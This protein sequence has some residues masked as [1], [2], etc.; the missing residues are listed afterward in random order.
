MDRLA[1]AAAWYEPQSLEQA[2]L[3]A[4]F[5]SQ[6]VDWTELDRWVAGEG[7]GEMPEVRA[8]YGRTRG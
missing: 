1:A 6:E 4:E 5:S 2:V 8:F 3:I 7:I